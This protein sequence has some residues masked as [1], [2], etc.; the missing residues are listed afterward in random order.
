LPGNHSVQKITRDQGTGFSISFEFQ[1]E[2]VSLPSAAAIKDHESAYAKHIAHLRLPFRI[3]SEEHSGTSAAEALFRPCKIDQ[4]LERERRDP[5][6]RDRV[7]A[8]E[9]EI[10]R[11]D[12]LM[13]CEGVADTR[14]LVC[15][16][17][18]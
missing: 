15:Y 1:P 14:F 5:C 4:G 17:I 13:G 7:V 8:G 11:G 16:L 10:G 9:W 6:P 12:A 2:P 18:L 3:L